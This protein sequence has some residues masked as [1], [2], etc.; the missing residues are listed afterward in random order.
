MT[1]M[2]D[3]SIIEHKHCISNSELVNLLIRIGV[4]EESLSAR[5]EDND[6]FPI[7]W[8][9][10]SQAKLEYL[11]VPKLISVIIWWEIIRAGVVR[12]DCPCLLWPRKQLPPSVSCC[13]VWLFFLHQKS[14]PGHNIRFFS[15]RH[16]TSLY[17]KKGREKRKKYCSLFLEQYRLFV[18]KTS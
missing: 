1:H 12:S 13:M 14:W 15:F 5:C 8:V 2:C 11:D 4:S 10:S 16:L 7:H 3:T 6:S 9:T 17:R 18:Y